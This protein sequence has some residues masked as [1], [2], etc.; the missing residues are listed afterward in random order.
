[1]TL[2]DGM[3][4]EVSNNCENFDDE[5]FGYST[6]IPLTNDEVLDLLNMD[7]FQD[8]DTCDDDNINNRITVCGISF[9]KLK[10]KMTNLFGDGKVNY[11]S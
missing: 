3:V 4:F 5:D 2:K 8:E 9:K 1:M 11:I 6:D 7:D 10:T